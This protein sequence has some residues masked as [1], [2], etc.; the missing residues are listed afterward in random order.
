MSVLKYNEDAAK[1]LLALYTTPDV[2]EQRQRFINS[3][4]IIPGDEILDVGSGPGFLCN[5]ISESLNHNVKI[6]GIDVS[7]PL[8]EYAKQKFSENRRLNFRIGNATDIPFKSNKFDIVISTQVLEYIE[9]VDKALDEMFR[10]LKPGGSLALLD[11][12]WGSIVWHSNEVNRMAKILKAWEIHATD[13]FLPRTLVNRLSKAGFYLKS[14]KIIPIYNSNFNEETYSNRL[15][16]LIVSFV[17]KSEDITDSE[18]V[19]WAKDLR[20]NGKE[21]RYFFSLNRYFFLAIK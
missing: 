10:V 13:P 2:I 17:T 4:D 7:E 19:S 3:V 18:A 8:I 1:Q 14:Q 12:D 15:I 20:I 21:G 9:N 6:F 11:T 16:D 5:E